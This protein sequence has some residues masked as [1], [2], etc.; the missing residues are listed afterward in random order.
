MHIR[1]DKQ[2]DKEGR[3]KF[4]LPS[5]LNAKLNIL[6]I[7]LKSRTGNKRAL[8]DFVPPRFLHKV[9]ENSLSFTEFLRTYTPLQITCRNS[10]IFVWA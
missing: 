4:A 9:S 3:G 2:Q 6:G 10:H 1:D 8:G 7:S 5:S